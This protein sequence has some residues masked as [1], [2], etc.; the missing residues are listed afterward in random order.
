MADPTGFKR[1]QRNPVHDAAVDL[2]VSGLAR[3]QVDNLRLEWRNKQLLEANNQL[4]EEKREL[5]RQNNQALA[6]RVAHLEDIL[7]MKDRFIAT[8]TKSVNEAGKRIEALKT[9]INFDDEDLMNRVGNAIEE[10]NCPGREG[11]LGGYDYGDGAPHSI[12]YGRYAIRD[13]RD[14]QRPSYGGVIFRTPDR[15]LFEARLE[16]MRRD[17]IAQAAMAVISAQ[18]QIG[19]FNV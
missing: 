14:P 12:R 13:F 1:E 2:L 15:E 8:L 11:P 7:A 16:K 5:K 9:G 17:H 10:A 4:V 18:M 6:E 19:T 3:A